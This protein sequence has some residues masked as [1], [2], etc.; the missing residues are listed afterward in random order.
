MFFIRN[1]TTLTLIYYKWTGLIIVVED[2][3]WEQKLK[4]R[5]N[6]GEVEA[7]IGDERVDGEEA[8]LGAVDHR[9]QPDLLVHG[10][11]VQIHRAALDLEPHVNL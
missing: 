2:S 6:L 10:L 7:K 5:T 11:P 3:Y 4:K 1:P 9:L 8:L